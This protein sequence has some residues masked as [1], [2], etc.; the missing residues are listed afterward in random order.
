MLFDQPYEDNKR[1][2]VTGPFT[3]ES[4]SPHRTISVQEKK[5]AADGAVVPGVSVKMIGAGQFGNIII[6]NLKKAG[7]QNTVK[8]DR[9]RFDRLEVFPGIWI[10]LT[11]AGISGAPSTRATSLPTGTPPA[12]IARTT[13]SRFFGREVRN[14]PSCFPASCRS[15]K[16]NLCSRSRGLSTMFPINGCSGA[17]ST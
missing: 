4:L 8:E 6:E 3:V 14:A 13:V 10:F 5:R 1:V 15:E 2:R 17:H 12:G 11:I 7:V 9:L 16:T